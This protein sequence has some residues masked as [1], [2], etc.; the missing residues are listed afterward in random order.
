MSHDRRQGSCAFISN[1][2][3]EPMKQNLEALLGV[4]DLFKHGAMES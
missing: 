2:V 4:V 1:G 3:V